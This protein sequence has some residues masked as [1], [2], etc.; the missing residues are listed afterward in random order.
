[1]ETVGLSVLVVDEDL[2]S[3]LSI[4]ATIPY[5]GGNFTLANNQHI[6]A[7]QK[8]PDDTAALMLDQIAR[9]VLATARHVHE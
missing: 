7:L 9:Q 6:P 2:R 8:M 4:Q 3:G 1:M 5:M